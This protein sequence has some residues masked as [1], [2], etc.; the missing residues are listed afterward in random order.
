[1]D[2]QATR[3]LEMFFVDLPR[4]TIIGKEVDVSVKER[5]DGVPFQLLE[6]EKSSLDKSFRGYER[7][8]YCNTYFAL[9][10]D[11]RGEG[12][13]SYMIGK[14]FKKP[15]GVPNEQYQAKEFGNCRAAEGLIK[16]DIS[17]RKVISTDAHKLISA[18]LNTEY[19]D[20]YALMNPIWTME[21][22]TP[23]YF[24]DVSYRKHAVIAYF[25]P[26]VGTSAGQAI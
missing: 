21:M 24:Q 10:G 6:S 2:T 17:N 14:V 4:L 8:M 26:V 1:M 12:A 23:D 15:I 25:V 18:K 20:E 16:A 22:Y 7:Y 13:M 5:L 11:R 3:I 19:S 9:R